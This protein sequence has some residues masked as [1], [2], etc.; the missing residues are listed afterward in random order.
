MNKLPEDKAIWAADQFIEYYSKFNRIDDYLRFVK[1]DR[2]SERPGS[3]FGA[4][5]EFF[6]T[7]KMHPN[8][9]NFKVHVV[10][11]NPKTTSRY[12]QWLY[13]ETLNLTASN[14]I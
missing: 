12:N 3:L 4:D 13:S 5:V 9:M 7:F 14:A 11:T 6:D 1:K 2:I 10:D 8:D